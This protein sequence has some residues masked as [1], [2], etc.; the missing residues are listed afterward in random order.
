MN[1]YPWGPIAKVVFDT[2]VLV[3]VYGLVGQTRFFSR[4]EFR[5]HFGTTQK[6]PMTSLGAMFK[7]FGTHG[8]S[9]IQFH[10][11][12]PHYVDAATS[13]TIG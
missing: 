8:I 5:G 12:L 4:R 7:N 9:H 10:V 1:T 3:Q 2:R 11:A 13:R 6:F